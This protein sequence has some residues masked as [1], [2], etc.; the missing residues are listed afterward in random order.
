M[1][2]RKQVSSFLSQAVDTV[3]PPRCVITGEM[4]ERQGMVAPGAWASLDFIVAPFC[5]ACGFPFEFEVEADAEGGALCGPCLEDRPS[6]ES[7]RAALK[8][9]DGSRKMIL[10]FKHADKTHAVKA[11][12]PWLKRTGQDMLARADYLVPVP[13]HRWRLLSRRYNQAALMAYSLTRETGLTCLPD[14]LFRVRATPSQGY[15]NAKER[16]KNVRRAFSFNPR[17]ATDIQGKTLVLVDDVYTT[18]AT[19]K[20]CVKVL[21]KAGAGKVHIL[22]L[23]RVVRE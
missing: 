8:Y 15:L 11:F 5:R 19:V 3:L 16:H 22:T 4:V 12:V 20:E 1:V 9:N 13:L 6:F 17:Y 21:L 2:V 18:G 14:A 10:G 23:A 7:A